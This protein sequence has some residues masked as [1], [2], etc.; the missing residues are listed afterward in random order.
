MHLLAVGTSVRHV[1]RSASRFADVD[2]VD[3][4]RDLDTQRYAE[5]CVRVGEVTPESVAAAIEDLDFDRAVTTSPNVPPDLT[6]LGNSVEEMRRVGDKWRFAEFCRGHGYPHPETRLEPS[7][8]TPLAKPRLAGG[9]VNNEV[10]R[11]RRDGHVYQEF[12]EGEPLSVS[13]VSDGD[14]ARAVAVN[15]TLSGVDICRPPNRFAYCGNITPADHP[16]ADEAAALAEGVVRDLGIRGSVGVDL[17]AGNGLTVLEVNPRLQASLDTVEATTGLSVT[18]LHVDASLGAEGRMESI[19]SAEPQGFACRLV[20]YADRNLAAPALDR[21]RVRDVPPPG[22]AIRRGEPVC[23]VVATGDTREET[24]K[25]ARRR[26]TGV[27]AH[28]D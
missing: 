9:G 3:E 27:R 6:L 20:V 15:R 8:D 10:T 7:P 16:A 12:L 14:D 1:A 28:L 13:V 24:V 2:T 19:S 21:G 23:S 17:I 25:E 18:R 4:F 26:V 5:R 11:E 22:R